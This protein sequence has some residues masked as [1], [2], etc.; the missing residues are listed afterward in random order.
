[1]LYFTDEERIFQGN[2]P[3]QLWEQFSQV[4]ADLLERLQSC[5]SI[6]NSPINTSDDED[7]EPSPIKNDSWGG[8]Y[9]KWVQD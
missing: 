1:M 3:D 2:P 8:N 9:E 5:M 4:A 6:T 7:L